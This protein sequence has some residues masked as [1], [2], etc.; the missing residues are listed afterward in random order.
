LIVLSLGLPCHA[1]CPVSTAKRTK[2]DRFQILGS[3]Q[4]STPGTRGPAAC[5]SRGSSF[6][7]GCLF[8]FSFLSRAEGTLSLRFSSLAG[9]R[10]KDK[11]APQ[12][13]RGGSST[14]IIIAPLITLHSSIVLPPAE[15]GLCDDDDKRQTHLQLA[16]P[17]NSSQAVLAANIVLRLYTLPRYI[18]YRIP[19]LIIEMELTALPRSLRQI[20]NPARRDPARRRWLA[21]EC[22]RT[23]IRDPISS[24]CSECGSGAVAGG[25]QQV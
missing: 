15:L 10:I 3:A 11:S 18:H 16:D 17:Q 13:S 7:V 24:A 9:P 23:R 25:K 22:R 20:R 2:R 4:L 19:R 21:E 6:R 1:A 8:G 14:Q 5:D 12:M